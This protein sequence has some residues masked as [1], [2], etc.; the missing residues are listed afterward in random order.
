MASECKY[1]GAT[2]KMDGALG[3]IRLCCVKVILDDAARPALDVRTLSELGITS[4]VGTMFTEDGKRMLSV[5]VE[6][7]DGRVYVV[8]DQK[9]ISA[10]VVRAV[11]LHSY[12]Q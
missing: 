9:D 5:S 4:L 8:Q 1:C 12:G 7:E 2:L 10:S 3:T 6:F 11:E